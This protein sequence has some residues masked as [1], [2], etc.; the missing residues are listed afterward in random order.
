M[1]RGAKARKA[2]AKA[3]VSSEAKERA[4]VSVSKVRPTLSSTSSRGK[5]PRRAARTNLVLSWV[6]VTAA[7]LRATPRR[8]L[9]LLLLPT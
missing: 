4:K 8:A 3:K 6:A 1:E 5:V 7:A 2:K 9:T